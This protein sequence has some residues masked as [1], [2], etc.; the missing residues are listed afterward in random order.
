MKKIKIN[1]KNIF[2]AAENLKIGGV[3]V[4]P[5]ETV[6]GL[7]A[8]PFNV[9][10]IKKVY[11]VKG[12][13][14]NKPLPLI[15][16]D[17]SVVKKYF[18]ISAKEMAL[19]KKYWPGALTLILKLK[20]QTT[21]HKKYFSNKIIENGSVAVR[22]SPNKIAHDLAVAA[23][24]FIVSTS[25]NISGEPECSDIKEILRQFKNRRFQPDLILDSGRLKKS[26][27]STIIKVEKGKVIILR[28]G[29][30]K[31]N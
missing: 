23:G 18:K 29:V 9:K 1:S 5:T 2:L 22:V 6:Y 16:A 21:K 20:T 15:A 4:F 7:A 19:A 8:D 12:R 31:L 28:Q 27:P 10:A 3:V 17:F 13:S 26:E 14:F 24:G 25:A 11:A 30:V